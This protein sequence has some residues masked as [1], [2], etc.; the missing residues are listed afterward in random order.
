MGSL[1]LLQQIFLTQESNWGLLHCRWIL[2]QLSYQGS[3]TP[4]KARRFAQLQTVHPRASPTQL[5][6]LQFPP[7]PPMFLYQHHIPLSKVS[8]TATSVTNMLRIPLA[9]IHHHICSTQLHA[10]PHFLKCRDHTHLHPLLFT[11]KDKYHMIS[12]ICGI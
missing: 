9:D 10:L 11:E 6:C 12:L 4:H 5:P 1:S 3:P 8:F 2:Y 7:S